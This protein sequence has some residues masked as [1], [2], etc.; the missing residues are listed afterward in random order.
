LV[1]ALT[2]PV[3]WSSVVETLD[4]LGATRFLEVGPGEV[5]TGLVRKTLGP[6]VEATT[7]AEPARA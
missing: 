2:A 4:E 1:D 7:I 3:R 6:E 5:L